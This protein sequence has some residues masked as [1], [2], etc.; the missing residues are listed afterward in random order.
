MRNADKKVIEDFGREWE[1]FDQSDLDQKE[2]EE[3]FAQ[4]FS[5]FPWQD[6]APDS[7]G[8]DLGC[9]SG[10]WARLAARRVGHLHCIEPSQAIEVAK[11][12]LAGEGN[13]SFHQNAVDAIPLQNNSMDFGYCLGVLHHVPDTRGGL[14]AC[15]GKLKPDAPFVLYLYYSFDNRPAWFRAIWKISDLARRAVSRAPFAVKRMFA[16]MM[17][18]FVYL[19]LAR[20]ARFLER[21]GKNVDAFPLSYYRDR[22]M[23]VMRTDALDRFGT[24]LEKRFSRAEIESMMHE[25]GLVNIVF[26]HGPPYWCAVGRRRQA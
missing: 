9:G 5:V 6:L 19:P 4:Y 10:R 3:A 14:G 25:A 2:A 16:W 13:V 18:F 11:R 22:S 8:F 15:V 12:T 24:R 21:R 20:T 1:L 23:Y 7:Q 17:A 26:R